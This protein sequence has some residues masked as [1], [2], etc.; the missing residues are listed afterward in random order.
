MLRTAG[1]TPTL[2]EARRSDFLRATFSARKKNT[3]AI[4]MRLREGIACQPSNPRSIPVLS[5][6]LGASTPALLIIVRSRLHI[7]VSEG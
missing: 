7:G 4:F 1:G 2:P 3:R 5:P 6:C